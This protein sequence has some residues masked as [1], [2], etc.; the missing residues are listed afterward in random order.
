MLSKRILII[1]P[2]IIDRIGLRVIL[3]DI[4]GE[5]AIDDTDN[6]QELIYKIDT[7]CPKVV[8][9]SGV[10]S[11]NLDSL[12]IK[13][14]NLPSFN[15]TNFMLYSNNSDDVMINNAVNWGVKGCILKTDNIIELTTAV[16]YLM[17]G[18]SYFSQKAS[19]IIVNSQA[20]KKFYG[21]HPNVNQKLTKREMSVLK[22]IVKGYSNKMISGQL[23]ISV[24]TVAI[25][26][27]NIMK[28]NNVKNAA[29]LVYR[30]LKDKYERTKR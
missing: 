9:L 19:F 16:E 12:F 23:N 1:E 11:D 2:A 22:L 8:I 27:S 7:G 29:E 10:S 15:N 30:S 24:H 13:I 17:T 20:E 28:K 3:S 21:S 4:Y 6:F 25:H 5:D 18:R 14:Q 26:R